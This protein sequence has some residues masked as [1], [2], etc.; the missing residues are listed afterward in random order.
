MLIQMTRAKRVV[1]H[2]T[3]PLIN[4]LSIHNTTTINNFTNFI[5]LRRILSPPPPLS[6]NFKN[7]MD[8]MIGLQ[9]K[10]VLILISVVEKTIF[11]FIKNT[12]DTSHIPCPQSSLQL[13]EA[14]RKSKKVKIIG[15]NH[16]DKVKQIHEH[17]HI[18]STRQ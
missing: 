6:Y 16:N 11:K 18:E 1:R 3:H 5:N 9:K 15:L 17:Q 10:N 14:G 12:F 7:F 8:L 4:S 13:I 2:V